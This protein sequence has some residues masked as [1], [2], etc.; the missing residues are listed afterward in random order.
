M[1]YSGTG[2]VGLTVAGLVVRDIA[3]LAG[4]TLLLVLY[5]I[6]AFP[7]F[8]FM[9]AHLQPTASTTHRLAYLHDLSGLSLD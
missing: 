4:A 5:S 3:G 6:V 1:A 9:L 7:V 2:H 8:A